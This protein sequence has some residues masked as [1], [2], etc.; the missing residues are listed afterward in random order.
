MRR[1][2]FVLV[3]VMLAFALAPG[4]AKGPG[5]ASR[6]DSAHLVVGLHGGILCQVEVRVDDR[7]AGRIKTTGLSSEDTVLLRAPQGAYRVKTDLFCASDLERR[8][9]AF[10]FTGTS[11]VVNTVHYIAREGGF[12]V[13][14]EDLTD[15]ELVR[16]VLDSYGE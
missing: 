5:S 10:S 2:P 8:S 11:G 4:C 1:I 16:K 6:S 9:D 15:P 14:T 7:L 3:F 13:L 12:R